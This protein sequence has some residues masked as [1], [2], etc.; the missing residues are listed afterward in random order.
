MFIRRKGKTELKWMPKTA[1]TAF[2][3]GALVSS[4]VGYLIPATS[5]TANITHM[6]VIRKAIAATDDD[7]ADNTKVPVEVPIE[8]FVEWEADFT[9]TLVVADVGLEV[10]ATDSLTL[11]RGAS[12]VDVAL[13]VRCCRPPKESFA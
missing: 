5:S 10:D 6:G 8:R 9:A 12:T 4:S 3:N 13:V 7:Y 11:N 2:S 1:S